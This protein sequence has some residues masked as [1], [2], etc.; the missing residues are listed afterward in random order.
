MDQT[1]DLEHSEDGWIPRAFRGWM[2]QT[3]DL[4]HSEDGWIKLE[5]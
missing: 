4:E 3:R 5:T 2:D 1:R